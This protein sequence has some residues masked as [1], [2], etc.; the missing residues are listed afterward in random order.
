MLPREHRLTRSRDFVRV[1]RR[2]RSVGSGLATLYIVPAENDTVRVGFSVSKRVGKAVIRNR[3][4]RLL[5]EAVRRQ[6][7]SI[8]PGCDLVFIA[9]PS[10]AQATYRQVLDAVSYLLR[11]SGALCRPV[12]RP[13]HA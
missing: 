2:G 5:R 3:V 12:P 13:D 11:R 9:R 8:R 10:A 7:L 6:L 4:K 1:R